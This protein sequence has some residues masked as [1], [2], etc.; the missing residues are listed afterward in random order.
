MENATNGQDI[1]GEGFSPRMTRMAR[2]ARM[3]EDHGW[4]SLL[5]SLGCD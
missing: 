5:F 4:F 2:M 3:R 1:S